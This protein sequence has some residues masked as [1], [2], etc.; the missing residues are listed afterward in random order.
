MIGEAPGAN[1]D[2]EGRPFVGDAGDI[3]RAALE[4]S[5][6]LP[7]A[8]FTNSVRCRPAGNREPKIAE[9]RQCRQYL[10]AEIARIRPRL[11]LAV[12]N[13]AGKAV[14][15]NNNFR[16]TNWRGQT[17][18]YKGVQV[19]HTYH[20]SA[21][22]Y[23]QMKFPL[24][25]QDVKKA[26]AMF[27]GNKAALGS[28]LDQYEILPL[29]QMGA[30][31]KS[32]EGQRARNEYGVAAFDVETRG[33]HPYAP[34][35]RLMSIAFCL[36][37]TTTFYGVIDREPSAVQTLNL[38]SPLR[39]WRLGGHS[40]VF[41]F[42]W[43]T[44]GMHPKCFVYSLECP[45]FDSLLDFQL[46]NELYENTSLD[47]LSKSF[48][49][50]PK[51]P[52][53]WYVSKGFPKGWRTKDNLR[54]LKKYNVRDAVIAWHLHM[55][56]GKK[57]WGSRYYQWA[58]ENMKLAVQMRHQGIRID[59]KAV[60]KLHTLLTERIIPR[61]RKLLRVSV[62][63]K[64]KNGSL[65]MNMN[66]LRT[67]LFDKL[68]LPVIKR[69]PE[70]KE[71]SVDKDTLD[72]LEDRDSSG[73]IKS[74]LSYKKYVKLRDTYCV[75]ML[76]WGAIAHPSIY[77]TR[78]AGGKDEADF[79]TVTGR[80]TTEGF[81]NLPREGPIKKLIISRYE[82]GRI[83]ALDY[84]QIEMRVAA[85]QSG[86]P[87]WIKAF[88]DGIDLHTATAA[89]VYKIPVDQV[90]KEQRHVGKTGNFSAL[91]GA[92]VKKLMKTLKVNQA[93]A[94]ALLD[95]YWASVP[96]L[97]RWIKQKQNEAA[98]TGIVY[99]PTGRPFHVPNAHN[100]Y[101]KDARRAINSIV[102]SPASEITTAAAMAV[103]RYFQSVGKDGHVLFMVYDS[104]VMDLSP[105]MLNWIEKEFGLDKW[106]K[107]YFHDAAL[108]A[109]SNLG[110]NIGVPITYEYALGKSYGHCKA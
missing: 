6:L 3:L 14:T 73:F 97:Q 26:A 65:K 9:I 16:I 80:P 53:P 34:T 87:V 99:S 25:E 109:M 91:Y 75:N 88:K 64:D 90:T 59:D 36:S 8:S 89:A 103:H 62:A 32:E 29:E 20:P 101:H 84:S 61:E 13:S 5:Y 102:Q 68:G 27:F 105:T 17:S 22:V 54:E 38:F 100:R 47:H 41:D 72:K 110:W 107:A 50:L 43:T 106:I 37:P 21:T 19:I 98:Q 96:T 76:K 46:E 58:C 104:V 55:L 74:M 4:D 108:K 95:S 39:T 56:W 28:G 1:E 33:L 63:S 83:L 71:P 12:G 42:C 15:D 44:L 23:D 45:W 60:R 67:H 85:D 79:G 82:G 31:V 66:A 57:H 52:R 86:E 24:F 69:T 77:V 48:L 51:F 70:T 78:S 35:S 11:I 81:S 49:G 93:E 18:E 2:E 92:S 30:W 94:Q 7:Y 40:S 10:D